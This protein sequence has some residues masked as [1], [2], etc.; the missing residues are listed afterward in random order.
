MPS[1]T[2]T[3]LTE[4]TNELRAMNDGMADVELAHV[5]ADRLLIEALRLT[6]NQDV[7]ATHQIEDVIAAWNEVPKW[8]A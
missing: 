3:R 4:I 7:F 1:A 5:T 8:Y 2:E 6:W